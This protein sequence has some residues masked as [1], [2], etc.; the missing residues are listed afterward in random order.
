MSVVEVKPTGVSASY[1]GTDPAEVGA[2]YRATYFVRCDSQVDTPDIVRNYFKVTS[3]LPW[4]GRTFKL[5]NGFDTDVFCVAVEPQ[6]IERSAGCFSVAVRFDP[7]G[8]VGGSNDAGTV[9]TGITEGGKVTEDP[10]QYSLEVDVSWNAI[11]EPAWD[12]KF[13]G[14]EPGPVKHP[15]LV[16][17]T[18]V[19]VVNSAMKVFDPTIEVETCIKVVRIT[20]NRNKYDSTNY[21]KFQG[22]VNNN[23]MN[24]GRPGVGFRQVIKPYYGKMAF[25]G[26]SLG[27]ENGKFFWRESKEVHIHP[28]SWIRQVVDEGTEELLK[29]GDVLA[30]GTSLSSSDFP[31]SRPWDHRTIRGDD[32]IP[33]IAPC[34][35]DGL[36]RRL[37]PDKPRV[38]LKYLP[39]LDEDWTSIPF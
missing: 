3:S 8:G 12:A 36:G 11:T 16:E 35:L 33:N 30:D 13:F 38:F 29:P 1:T 25:Y 27:F 14:I 24:I 18:R 4:I 26:A 20:Q 22:T 28:R 2:S 32:G 5:G 6:Y 9:T 39:E 7:A 10:L 23:T 21:D 19:A 37:A 17:G 31:A 34:P 15:F